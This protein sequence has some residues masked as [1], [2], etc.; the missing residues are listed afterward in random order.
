MQNCLKNDFFKMSFSEKEMCFLPRLSVLAASFCVTKL[1]RL[2][3]NF[4]HFPFWP[5]KIVIHDV[6]QPGLSVDL[7]L[8]FPRLTSPIT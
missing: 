6:K 3:L 2:P 1:F 8:L 5:S 4:S 7:I